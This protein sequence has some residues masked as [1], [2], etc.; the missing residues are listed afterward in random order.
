MPFLNHTWRSRPNRLGGSAGASPSPEPSDGLSVRNVTHE[1]MVRDVSF[2]VRRGEI[3]A[4]TGL[5][6]AGRT[7]TARLI[8][9]AD[10]MESGTVSLDGRLLDVKKPR[11]AIRAGICLL[12]EDRKQQGLVLG[13]SVLENFGLPNMSR[14]APTGLIRQSAERAAFDGYVEQL[15]IK[16]SGPDQRAANLSGGNQQ[17]IVLAKWLEQNAEVIIFDEP[18][19]GIDVGAKFEIYSLINRLADQGKVILMISSELPEVLGMA[20]RIIVMHEGR[21]TGEI[22]DVSTATQEMI[23][24]LAVR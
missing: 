24:D 2:N 21:V 17:K 13:R 12:T 16:V 3:V 20:D 5:V 19:R 10:R 7:E 4:L 18:T 23:M 9:G 1:P 14:F 22:S 11:H 8:F 15:Q 6:G